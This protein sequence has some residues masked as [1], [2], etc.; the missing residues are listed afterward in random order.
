MPYLS[1]AKIKATRYQ[2][3][4]TDNIVSKDISGTILGFE[5]ALTPST[6]IEFGSENNNDEGITS[7][8]YVRLTTDLQG[9]CGGTNFAIA[10]QAFSNSNIVTLTDL[11][12]VERS[13]QNSR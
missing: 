5:V 7:A 10:H 2:W 9:K 13:K 11:D 1:W 3:D 4:A 12:R 8:S 6:T